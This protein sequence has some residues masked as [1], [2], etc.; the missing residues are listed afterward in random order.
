MLKLVLLIDEVENSKDDIINSM[1][2]EM[3]SCREYMDGLVKI[4]N[5]LKNYST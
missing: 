2:E 1:W 5:F 4:N 3:K